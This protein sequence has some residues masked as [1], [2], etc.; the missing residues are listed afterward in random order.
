M[1]KL[2]PNVCIIVSVHKKRLLYFQCIGM[3]IRNGAR[4][5]NCVMQIVIQGKWESYTLEFSLEF[6]TSIDVILESIRN[7]LLDAE[8]KQEQNHAVKNLIRRL[9]DALNFADNLLDEFV[10]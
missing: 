9:K 7:V 6:S 8:D 4:H 1:L 3:K 5:F 2:L 10:I